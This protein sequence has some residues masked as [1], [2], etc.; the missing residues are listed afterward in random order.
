[1]ITGPFR[2]DEA[3]AVGELTR[4][5]LF[6][7][8]F[9]RL[10]PGVFAPAGLAV[11]FATRT[12][13]AY[14]LVRGR[15]GVLA[16]YSAALLLGAGCAPSDAPAEVL[17]PSDARG[18]PGLRVRRDGWTTPRSL[19]WTAAASPPPRAP[20]GPGSPVAAGGSR[21]R[22]GLADAG[23]QVPTRRPADQT[24]RRTARQ[25]LPAAGRGDRPLRLPRGV[26]D[27][28]PPAARLVRGGLP[29][30]EVQHR[31]LD[32][33]GFPLARVDLAYPPAR[34]AIEY[35][36]SGHLERRRW[37]RDRARDTTLAGEG[38]QTL[39]VRAR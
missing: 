15:G 27:G 39:P 34:L 29:R 3:I 2:G 21:G 37:S 7:P 18:H 13:A 20:H 31:V 22:G 25:G 1:M 36:G 4:N 5:E 16:G 6:G 14:L 23:R 12:R 9:Q 24:A 32:E 38:W 35:D 33:R 19:G 28:D 10:F 30:P 8:R 26:T 17:V 11:D